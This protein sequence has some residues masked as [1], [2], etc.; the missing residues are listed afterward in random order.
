MMS[1]ISSE[2]NDQFDLLEVLV[3]IW[4][5]KWLISAFIVASIFCGSGFIY[6]NE[7]ANNVKY[8]SQLNYS[9]DIPPPFSSASQFYLDFEKMFFSKSIFDEVK[10]NYPEMT[11]SYED[12]IKTKIVNG[13]TFSKKENELLVTFERI[14]EGPRV[15]T[16]RT[17]INVKT[18]QPS[19]LKNLFTYANHIN[20]GLTNKYKLR[21]ESELNFI[22]ETLISSKSYQN[23]TELGLRDYPSP[24]IIEQPVEEEV[25]DKYLLLDAYLLNTIN[26]ENLFEIDRPTMPLKVSISRRF[27]LSLSAMFGGIIGGLFIISRQFIRQFKEELNET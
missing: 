25:L 9:I 18:N 1:K 23:Y 21:A 4:N 20:K 12:L 10:L 7:S 26:G 16:G 6:I 22:K 5:G 24:I 11:L 13:F 8:E 19:L 3:A 15:T 27:I 14:K 17:F 2:S